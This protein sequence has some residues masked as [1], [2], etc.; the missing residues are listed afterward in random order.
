MQYHVCPSNVHLPPVGVAV[1]LGVRRR[2]GRVC[3]V[4]RG[5]HPGGDAVE[6]AVQGNQPPR[7]D[8]D[9]CE[10]IKMKGDIK[11]YKL[12]GRGGGL[13]QQLRIPISVYS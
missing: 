2:D 13:G 11:K 6:D 4:V 7:V 3:G 9:T 1:R 12:M 5:V 8:G 10:L